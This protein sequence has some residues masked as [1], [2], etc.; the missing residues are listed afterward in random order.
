MKGSFFTV[1]LRLANADCEGV[2]D[3]WSGFVTRDKEAAFE[4]IRLF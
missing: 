2:N 4:E 3:Q 1:P